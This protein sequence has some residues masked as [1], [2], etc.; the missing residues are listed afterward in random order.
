MCMGV[1]AETLSGERRSERLLGV[2]VWVSKVFLAL[3]LVV[4]VMMYWFDF[5]APWVKSLLLFGGGLSSAVWLS[6]QV[7]KTVFVIAAGV[8]VMGPCIIIWRA[9]PIHS[10][11]WAKIDRVEVEEITG[12]NHFEITDGSEL[13]EFG[14]FGSRGRYQSILKSGDS[15]HITVWCGN[16][17]SGY[18]VHGNCFG[19]MPGG[20]SQSVFVP[21]EPGFYM[22]FSDLLVRHGHPRRR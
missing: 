10:L 5:T 9:L 16:E 3:L 13:L 18:Y 22:W 4:G 17:G 12:E 7:P 15:Y 14:K 1:M 21:A 19:E 6:Q 11:D 2:R 20:F 8:L